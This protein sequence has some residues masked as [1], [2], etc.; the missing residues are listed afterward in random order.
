VIVPGDDGVDR[1]DSLWVRDLASNRGFPIDV[2]AGW[3]VTNTW[4]TDAG[5]M[6]RAVPGDQFHADYNGGPYALFQVTDG[7][8]AT[9][10]FEFGASPAGTPAASPVPAESE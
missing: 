3:S 8:A 7:S 2:P 9:K 1:F 5:L 10:V 6:F 4:W